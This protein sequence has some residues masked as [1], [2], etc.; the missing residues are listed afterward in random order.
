MN[1]S[2]KR[3]GNL[4]L[5]AKTP[6]GHDVYMDAREAN[7]GNDSAPTPMELL[8]T[9]LMGCTTMDVV[10]ILKKMKLEEY[11]YEAKVNFKKAEEHPKIYTEI[12]LIYIFKG[13]NL[14]KEK[15]EKAV[16]LSQE[17]YC[18]ISAMLRQTTRIT[19]TIKYEEE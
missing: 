8:L 11:D 2:L 19:H 5:H 17:K 7:G 15:I 9:A 3:V 12:E 1:F 13:K 4:A 16:L 10:S 6:T 18:S 14:P